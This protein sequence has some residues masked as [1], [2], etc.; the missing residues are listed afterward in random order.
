MKKPLPALNSD[1]EAEAFVASADLTDYDLSGITMVKFEF[2]PKTERVNMRL[3]KPLLD[4]VKISAEK[5]GM[6]YQRYIRQVLE[7]SLRLEK[8]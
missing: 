8:P 4:A 2:Q 5:A 3:P 7:T 1:A 6:P